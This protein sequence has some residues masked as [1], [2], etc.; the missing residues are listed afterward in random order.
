MKKDLNY[1]AKE[2]VEGKLEQQRG[3]W[4]SLGRPFVRKQEKRYTRA[5][6]K[7]MES[8]EG[9]EVLSKLLS[10][11]SPTVALTAAVYL[12]DTSAE[13]R[14]VETLREYAR[15]PEEDF[16][17]HCARLRLADWKKQKAQKR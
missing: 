10:H 12:L 2:F 16:H 11:E 7:L 8:E 9:V 3:E 5:L 4:E 13:I 15:G 1:Y 17:A 14:A 6:E